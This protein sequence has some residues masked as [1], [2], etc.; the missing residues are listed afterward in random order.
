VTFRDRLRLLL[1]QASAP[2]RTGPFDCAWCAQDRRHDMCTGKAVRPPLGFG[3]GVFGAA[4]GT[5]VE[6][7]ACALRGHLP[8]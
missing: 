3:A 4:A 8:M 1:A 7:C 5:V 2:A 6:D